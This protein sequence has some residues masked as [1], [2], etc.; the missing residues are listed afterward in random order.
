M[1]K[2]APT[3][4]AV[5]ARGEGARVWDVDGKDYLDFLAGIAVNSLGHAHPVFVEAVA[6][7][8]AHPRARLQLLR[9]R[10]AARARRAP[11]PPHRRRPGLLRQLR[12]GG[13]R[14]RDQA[15]P[16]DRA[17]PHPRPR[18]LLPRPHH[19]LAR[20]H[21]QAGAARSVP[22]ADP[23]RR[24]HRLDDRGARSGARRRMSRRSSSSRSRAR[25]AS[26]SCPPATSPPRASSPGGTARCSS[27]TRS[28]PARAA[29]ATG[30]PT[31]TTCRPASF[32][33]RWRSPRG[34]AAVSRSA[35]WSPSAP[36]ATCSAPATT[37]APSAATRSPPRPRT[38][39][40][41][42]SSGPAWSRTRASAATQLRAH[43]LA[44][45]LA[46]H[47]RHPGPRPAARRRASPS[48]SRR[49]VASRALDAGLI[50]NAANEHRIRLAPPL[51]IGDAG[52]RRVHPQVRRTPSTFRAPPTPETT[53]DPPLPPRRRP[54]PGRADRDPR[55]RR[56]GQGRPLGPH[57]AR[58]S[59]DRRRDLRQVVDP[60]AGEL[61][62]RHRRSRRQPAD[63]LD[64]EQPARRQGDP[65][66]HGPR[67]R[68][69][70]RGDRL[71]HLRAVGARGDGRRHA[72]AGHQR[73]ERRLP[74]VP[75]ARRPADDPRAQGHA[76]PASRSR[77]SATAPATWRTATCSPARPR[78]CT[79][80]SRR[81][82]EFSPV[83]AVVADADRRAAET[84]GSITL[85]TDPIEAVAGADVVV[86]DTWVSMG[87]ED[88]KAHRVAVFGAYQ[89]DDRAH[90]AR[91][92]RR[93]LPAL[94]ARRPR[95]R[96]RQPR[97]STDRRASSGTRRRTACTPRRRCWSGCW[98]GRVTQLSRSRP[99]S[100]KLGSLSD[101]REHGRPRR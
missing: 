27:S 79:C 60:H 90:V 96:G 94:P 57:A 41:A 49:R 32:R 77:S 18:E 53:H 38:P 66:R 42:R 17:A 76:S 59:A 69:P 93:D 74:P 45:R 46:A 72:R 55:P 14:G 5:L 52:A 16:P 15:R 75:A 37:A 26:S 34:S 25:R 56:D 31:S 91:E 80:A 44:L 68:A 100:T 8:A 20:A 47:H 2:S 21:R 6:R 10:A 67:A 85:Y 39:C 88:E 23:R 1:M 58:G 33:M 86:T 36:R 71:A 83:D 51:I 13:D 24:A 78:A 65:V 70:G 63:H 12:R 40:S 50:I 82:A 3:P 81:P 61:R 19:G 28:R 99:W 98:S 97:S 64:G 48:R 7:Q 9:D 95:L 101:D 62:G 73:A 11:H 43:I 35:R 54:D 29:P 22:A 87:K 30:S 84:G 92:G 89:V 4:L